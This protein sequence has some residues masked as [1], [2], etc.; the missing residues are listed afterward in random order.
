MKPDARPA[1]SSGRAVRPDGTGPIH[2]PLSCFVHRGPCGRGQTGKIPLLVLAGPTAAGKTA[3]AVRVAE[4]VGG[5]IISADA[6][7]IYRG[8][9]VGTAQPTAQERAR[10][11]F[12]L[13]AELEP[14]APFTVADFQSRAARAIEEVWQRGN[15]PV[16]CGGTGLYLRALLRHFAIPAT[17]DPLQAEIRRRLQAE[18]QEQGL[19]ALYRRLR[20]IDPTAAARIAPQDERRIVRALEVWEL[21]GRRFSE[22]SGV[23]RSA[24]ARYNAAAYVLTCPR[25]LLHQRIAS[26]VQAMLAS[27]WLEEV[28][29]LRERGLAPDSQ[30]MQALG[31]A[32]LWEVLE[33]RT[34]L[35]DA[36]ERIKRETRQYAKRQLTWL[37][38]EYGFTWM[39]W[40]SPVEYECFA[41]HL[42]CVGEHLKAAALGQGKQA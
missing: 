30:A 8:M 21:T 32:A 9:A 38:R 6:F 4:A 14:T 10:A 35:P 31:Y 17:R 19:P 3:M 23:D 39:T 29:A 25:E 16:L 40:S 36:E 22:A 18:A 13:V 33:G 12:H 15:L 41:G 7:Q 11:R 2:L 28:Q 42:L 24:G 27:G 37:R 26:R 34:S 20:E 1:C 5:E